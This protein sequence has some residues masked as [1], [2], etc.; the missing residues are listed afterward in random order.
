MR[1]DLLNRWTSRRNPRPGDDDR[2]DPKGDSWGSDSADR[3]SSKSNQD[4]TEFSAP[5]PGEIPES[6]RL[7][8]PRSTDRR[9]VNRSAGKGRRLTVRELMAQMNAEDT[10][11]STNDDTSG[12][13]TAGNNTAGNSTGG[14][15]DR[16]SAPPPAPQERPTR[17][18]R[19]VGPRRRPTGN[20]VTQKIPPVA[21][22][23]ESVDLSDSATQ[24]RVIEESRGQDAHG[25]DSPP[26][27]AWLLPEAQRDSAPGSTTA[28]NAPADATA[29]RSPNVPA[30]RVDETDQFSPSP[31]DAPTTALPPTPGPTRHDPVRPEP[32]RSGSGQGGTAA[33]DTAAE[34]TGDDRR[35]AAAAIGAPAAAGAAG[36]GGRGRPHTTR[37]HATRPDAPRPGRRP[38]ARRITLAGRIM[39]AFACITA[40]VGTGVVWGYVKSLDGNWRQILAL[41]GD[42]E[43]V[44]NIDAQY[45]DENYLIVGTDTRAGNNSQLGAGT[46]DDADGARADTVIL[47][48]IPADRSRVVAVSFPRDLQV[49][50]PDCKAWDS[51]SGEYTDEQLYAADQVKL[52]GVYAEGGPQC[53]VRV[54]TQMSGLKINRFMAMDFAG[55]REVVDVIGGVEVCSRVP[56]YDYELGPILRQPGTH[57][58]NADRALDYVRARNIESEGNGDYGRIKRQQL[59]MSSLLRSSLSGNVLAN[60]GKINNIVDTFVRYSFVDGVDTKSLVQLAESMQGLDAGRV[61]FLT[62]PTSGTSMD[63]LN[64][65]IPRLDDVDAIFDAII[66]D[67]PLPGEHDS[68]QM[69][70][71]SDDG[72][73]DSDSSGSDDGGPPAPAPAPEPTAPAAPEEVS[74]TAQNPGN[75]SVRVLNGTGVGGAAAT[76][77]E[78]LSMYGF[79]VTGR[80]D[81][82]ENRPDTVVRYGEGEQDSAA[83]IAAMLPGATIQLDRTVRSGV[84]VIIGSD[85][86]GAPEAAPA[87]GTTL[88]TTQLAQAT[89]PAN[90]PNDLAI[91]NAGDSTCT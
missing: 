13:N 66:D 23:P 4:R 89:S 77:S 1:I 61:S 30:P 37:P 56:L 17:A 22:P 52:N 10:G 27:P 14:S 42:D 29:A 60:P 43:D 86:V 79:N 49:D 83:T 39:V 19:P 18:H 80:A 53:L 64:N 63:G 70:P 44:R 75:V 6:Y 25:S 2:R 90:L 31:D 12:N 47:V 72:S 5:P 33:E 38:L 58:L 48:N 84:H 24:R 76:M 50:R 73:R 3:N 41:P 68:G 26:T 46:T 7:R 91:T 36:V 51:A 16:S 55:F 32:E 21:G 85:F 65:E 71:D 57:T 82:S 28:D 11:G 88:T 45:G 81:A 9:P 78:Q 15:S 87:P 54:I 59:F 62:I 40:L 20:D 74:T 8:E 69:P 35:P 34:D 67:Q